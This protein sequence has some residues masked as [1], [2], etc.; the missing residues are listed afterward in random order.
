M[1]RRH[2][3]AVCSA[4]AITMVKLADDD[5]LQ[6]LTK[7]LIAQPPD[8]LI[9]N[10]GIG[11]RGWV[12]A[13]DG[14]GLAGELRAALAGARTVARGP[15]ATGALRAAGLREEWSPRSESSREVLAHLLESGVDGRRIA[16]QL[17]GAT[18]DWDPIPEY[19][20]ELR[21]AGAMVVP[22]QVY[23][24]RPVPKGGDFDQLVRQIGRRQVDAVAFT[25][26]PAAAATLARAGELGIST[27]ILDALRTDVRAMCVGPVTA[28][29]LTRAGVPTSAP[30][31]MRLGALA[32]HIAD[33]LPVLRSRTIHAA[34]HVIQIRGSCVLVDGAVRSLSRSG[35][36]TLGAL[37]AR[38]GTV[39]SRA[40]L[41][42]LLPG[43]GTDTHAVDTA[44]LRLRNAL[45][46]KAIVATVVKRGYRLAIDDGVGA[47]AR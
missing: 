26:A 10:T 19:V 43:N 46:D 17:H 47:A 1:L 28:K 39:V 6:E 23:R 14:W 12:S 3:A 25:S 4:P 15:K 27:E 20:S 38:P 41:L 44:V 33:E 7:A 36:A 34:G 18:D 30:H 5:H 29:P 2:G 40:D 35:L 16:L 11:F 13:A 22:I 37:A 32:R 9:A 21:A 42:R 31:R 8:I 45:G 24:W